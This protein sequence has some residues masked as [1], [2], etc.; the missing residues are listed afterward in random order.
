MGDGKKLVFFGRKMRQNYYF[1]HFDDITLQQLPLT[2]FMVKLQIYLLSNE[3]LGKKGIV[4]EDDV[5]N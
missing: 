1:C 2:F 5:M 3:F 4:P